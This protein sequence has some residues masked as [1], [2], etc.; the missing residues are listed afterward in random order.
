MSRALAIDIGATHVAVGV[1]DVPPTPSAAERHILRPGRGLAADWM[2]GR[3][4]YNAQPPSDRTV[5]ETVAGA[6]QGQPAVAVALVSATPDP[7][8]LSGL[9]LPGPM[10]ISVAEAAAAG[11]IGRLGNQDVIVVDL[12][13]T[14]AT[15]TPLSWTGTAY[16]PSSA[17][18]HAPAASGDHLDRLLLNLFAEINPEIARALGANDAVQASV[19]AT[20]AH[21]LKAALSERR[22]ASIAVPLRAGTIEVSLPRRAF[23]RLAA[24]GAEQL[25][26]V[27]ASL[28]PALRSPQILFTGGGAEI[29]ALTATAQAITGSPPHIAPR[30]VTSGAL[31]VLAQRLQR[32]PTTPSGTGR[33]D[34]THAST[35]APPAAAPPTGWILAIDL[36]THFVTAA[37]ADAGRPA[38]AIALGRG[39]ARMPAAVHLGGDGRIRVGHDALA[40]AV[41]EPAG[42]E[43][44]PRRNIADERML[45]GEQV[46]AVAD[47]LARLLGRVRELAHEQGASPP[48]QVRLTHPAQWAGPRLDRLRS[49]AERA[50]LGRVVLVP[51]P[52]ALA[53]AAGLS[54][55]GTPVAVYD[56]GGGTLDTAVLRGRSGSYELAGEP[57]QRDPAGGELIDARIVEHIGRGT[58]GE[59][60]AWGLLLNDPDSTW[61]ARRRELREQVRHAKE[62]LSS[63]MVS[64]V[65]LPGLNRDYQLSRETVN[66][67]ATEVIE[68]SLDGLATTA[69]AAGLE[70]TEITTICVAGGAS[71]MPLVHDMIRARFGAEIRH[72]DDPKLAVALG[73]ATIGAATIS[74]AASRA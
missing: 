50:G 48:A 46:V 30:G 3:A 58:V 20:S 4:L 27:I 13:A 41:D 63:A 59:L 56:L 62:S 45:L 16:R 65:R 66:S 23:D 38:T 52:F 35:P 49:A 61:Q 57:A 47:V 53:A 64:T 18:Q 70:P 28:A 21:T 24:P 14:H 29:P 33:V 42:L 55:N 7:G 72:F 54:P 40:A 44:T 15:V 43:E 71:R 10:L 69:A 37:R 1:A 26:H 39:E 5:A 34:A 68:R 8:Q 25:A 17:P 60:E 22:V 19:I 74:A 73:A 2:A 36:G 12:G 31:S 32:R 9:G 11:A 51:E 6:L 67:L